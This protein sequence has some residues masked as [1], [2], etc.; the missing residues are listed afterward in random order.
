MN[1]FVCMKQTYDLQQVRIRKETRQPVLEN[2]PLTL[3]NIDKNALEE[4]IRIKEKS[5]GKITVLSA[6]PESLEDTVKEALAMGADEAVLITALELDAIESAL[7]AVL[8]AKAAAQAGPYDLIFLGEG[9][10]D[11]YSGQVG[12]RLAEL[13][14]LPQITFAKSLS[15]EGRTLRAVRSLE[16]SLEEVE[17]DLPALVTMVSEINEPRIPTVTQILKAGRKPKKVLRPEELGVPLRDFA[18]QVQTLSN[19]APV[20]NRRGILFKE[21]AKEIPALVKALEEEGLLR[22]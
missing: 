14:D 17:V 22:R 5:G 16:D 20:Q 9:S 1:I 15:L 7:S 4:A 8:L 2:V 13:L 12:P 21:G 6:G 18:P 10:T 3:G 11:S 19:L